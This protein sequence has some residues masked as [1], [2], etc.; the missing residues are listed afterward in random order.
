[1]KIAI[2]IFLLGLALIIG[3]AIAVYSPSF[4]QTRSTRDKIDLEETA[5]NEYSQRLETSI[6]KL[7]VGLRREDV[8]KIIGVAPDYLS[9]DPDRQTVTWSW[10]AVRHVGE[11][12]KSQGLAPTKGYFTV[13]VIF[14]RDGQVEKIISG[15]N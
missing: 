6:P 4:Y 14:N 7:T 8:E 1:M 9:F 15:I 13:A 12:R 3:G 11:L 5:L 10:D 2:H